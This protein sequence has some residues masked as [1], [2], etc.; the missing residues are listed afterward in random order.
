MSDHGSAR[1][2]SPP[3]VVQPTRALVL[4]F[5]PMP[6]DPAS[7]S[8]P[9]LVIIVA[10]R[11]GG[12]ISARSNIR[13]LHTDISVTC[14]L[15]AEAP[16]PTSPE[17]ESRRPR[18]WRCSGQAIIVRQW[19]FATD[20]SASVELQGGRLRRSLPIPLSGSSFSELSN[21]NSSRPKLRCWCM[22]LAFGRD[23]HVSVDEL[24]LMLTSI[25]FPIWP[26]AKPILHLGCF[27]MSFLSTPPFLLPERWDVD[28][29][30]SSHRM[31][32]YRRSG[33]KVLDRPKHVGA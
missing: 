30:R 16:G 14:P 4:V 26:R 31:A 19:H 17:L 32:C 22:A 28:K 12:L 29:G 1:A 24:N 33:S 27:P 3:F 8:K 20:F 9:L 13:V 21:S 25:P 2:P 18:G 23:G 10:A 5:F 11:R 7:Y 15:L 6:P